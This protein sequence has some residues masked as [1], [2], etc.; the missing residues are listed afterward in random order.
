MVQNKE[1]TDQTEI[2]SCERFVYAR[3]RSLI[4]DHQTQVRFHFVFQFFQFN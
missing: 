2:K 1:I 4:V 3:L